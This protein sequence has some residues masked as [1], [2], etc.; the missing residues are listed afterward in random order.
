MNLIAALFEINHYCRASLSGLNFDFKRFIIETQMRTK[1]SFMFTRKLM[2]A[3][4]KL[5]IIATVSIYSFG[6]Y[7]ETSQEVNGN[8]SVIFNFLQSFICGINEMNV[9]HAEE[10]SLKINDYL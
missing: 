5:Q 1:L 4:V 6:N 9:R 10:R 7:Y 2:A 8:R 3:L